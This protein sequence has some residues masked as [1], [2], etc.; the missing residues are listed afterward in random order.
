LYDLRSDA[1]EQRNLAR[2]ESAAA[3]KARLAAQLDQQLKAWRDPRATGGG[4]EFDRYPYY[5]SRDPVGLFD[6]GAAE[7]K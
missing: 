3:V 5:G 4:Q 1:G 6:K 7:K 2:Q